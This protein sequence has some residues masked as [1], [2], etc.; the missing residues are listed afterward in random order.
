[1]ALE[2]SDLEREAELYRVGIDEGDAATINYTNLAHV[3]VELGRPEE[4]MEALED[5]D[6][7]F[8]DVPDIQFGIVDAYQAMDDYENA[9]EVLTSVAERFSGSY[10]A[11]G[12]VPGWEAV[13]AAV[14]G[15]LGRVR[16]LSDAAVPVAFAANRIQDLVS[17]ALIPA[18]ADLYAAGDTAR[19]VAAVE[20]ILTRY[21]LVDFEPADRET[22]RFSDF[23]VRAGD[24]GR[25][26]ALLDRWE[27]DRIGGDPSPSF[28]ESVRALIA[29]EEGD[30]DG[31]IL[32]L[33]RL[34]APGPA[35]CDMCAQFDLGVAQ[36]RAGHRDAAIAAYEAHVDTTGSFRLWA[37]HYSIPVALERLGALLEER[38]READPPTPADLEA[39]ARYDSRFVELWAD[40]DEELQPRVRAAQ[41]RLEAIL[42][43]TG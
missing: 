22:L 35:R 18:Y 14:R 13:Q 17:I 25:A 2:G 24:P 31:A 36:E 29:L 10:D 8:P 16:S 23:F 1:M 38:A 42:K 41:A 5:A 30:V 27:S 11:D 37:A 21:P 28:Y 19:A 9:Q 40:A 3:L 15:R 32:Q 7:R 33:K 20:E 26:R 39:A 34:S 12:L 4:A 43:E 6:R